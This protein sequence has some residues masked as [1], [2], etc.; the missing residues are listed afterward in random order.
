MC[1]T[2]CWEIQTYNFLPSSE[3]GDS[4][5]W[6]RMKQ[7]Q[8]KV[9]QLV[10]GEASFGSP[11]SLVLRL[12]SAHIFTLLRILSRYCFGTVYWEAS[13]SHFYLYL[14]AKIKSHFLFKALPF[15]SGESARSKK[16][17]QIWKAGRRAWKRN[18]QLL[19]SK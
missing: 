12:C 4:A 13:W 17:P 18:P 2:P 19:S 5:I 14:K 8:T 9:P 15:P 11:I 16:R 1:Q 3:A 6:E 7:A 10:S